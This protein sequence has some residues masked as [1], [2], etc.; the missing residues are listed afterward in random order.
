MSDALARIAA[1]LERLSP[2]Q[3]APA[4]WRAAPGYF[5]DGAARPVAQIVAPRLD[6]LKGIDAQKDLVTANVNRLA[7]GHAA[8]DMLL[9]GSRGM[10]KSA[11]LRSAILAAQADNQ[12]R[13]ALVQIAPDAL[14]S[15]AALFTTLRGVAGGKARDVLSDGGFLGGNSAQ[16][17]ERRRQDLRDGPRAGA[18]PDIGG[19]GQPVGR[20]KLLWREAFECI[21]N[22][23]EKLVAGAHPASTPASSA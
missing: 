20:R 5:W 2:A 10:G 1:A 11:L 14:A 3:S 15:L 12:A 9:W 18:V 21:R 7:A 22:P 8:H 16:Q 4:E 19:M 13:V 6:L 23:R 17:I